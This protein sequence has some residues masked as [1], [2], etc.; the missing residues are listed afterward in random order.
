MKANQFHDPRHHDVNRRFVT[1]FLLKDVCLKCGYQVEQWRNGYDDMW[2]R[3]Q[4]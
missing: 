2:K 3:Y 1:N 4:Y